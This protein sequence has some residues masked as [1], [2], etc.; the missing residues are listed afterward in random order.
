VSQPW[1]AGSELRGEFGSSGSAVRRKLVDPPWHA[2][3]VVAWS[4][5]DPTKGAARLC[6]R[7]NGLLEYGRVLAKGG[8]PGRDATHA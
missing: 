8:P 4:R 5:M 7:D 1:R 2:R 6:N 3:K